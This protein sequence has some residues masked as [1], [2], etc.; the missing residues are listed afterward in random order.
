MDDRFDLAF[1]SGELLDGLGLDY[2]DGSFHVFGNNGTHLLNMPITTGSGA[3]LDVLSALTLASD[4]LPIVFQLN[5]AGE[6]TADLTGN[7]LVDFE[8]LTV[9]LAHWNKPGATFAE[10]NLVETNSTSVDFADLTVLL[11]GWTGSNP[12]PTPEAVLGA[13]AVPEP[14][15]LLLGVI[16]TLGLSVCWRGRRRVT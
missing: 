14:P 5:A 13:E 16:A 2:M 12:A 1:A 9:L 3:S 11:A 8:D 4:H 15:G 10:G 6:P 7:G